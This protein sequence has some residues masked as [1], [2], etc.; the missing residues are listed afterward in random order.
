MNEEHLP[1]HNH[2]LPKSEG[3]DVVLWLVQLT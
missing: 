2:S 3:E 1:F